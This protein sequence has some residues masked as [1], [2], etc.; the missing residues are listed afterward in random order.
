MA[1]H[2]GVRIIADNG[3]VL[4]GAQGLLQVPGNLVGAHLR[5]LV[6]GRD[7]RR[8]H[9]DAIFTGQHR[10]L[11]A[12][13]EKRDMRV[14]F[15]LGDAQLPQSEIGDV[16]SEGVLQVLRGESRRQIQAPPVMGHGRDGPQARVPR[17][18]KPLE[19]LLA[20]GG[21][22]LPHAIGPVVSEDQHIPV[23][24]AR[25]RGVPGLDEGG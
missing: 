25:H 19:I 14:F 11:A 17:A 22:Q 3:I 16:S 6:I 12:I 13:E 4:A 9:Q 18:R 21:R 15:G 5:T 8:R 23:L 24:H 20:E 2:I 10:L 7:P 1:H